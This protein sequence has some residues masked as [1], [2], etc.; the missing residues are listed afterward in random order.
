[1]F[2]HQPA[3][4]RVHNEALKRPEWPPFLGRV[5][6]QARH[7]EGEGRMRVEERGWDE[8]RKR[9]KLEKERRDMKEVKDCRGKYDTKTKQ[10]EIG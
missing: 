7:E 9:K 10:K 3:G 1:M 4:A 6:K 8:G 5:V 2:Q